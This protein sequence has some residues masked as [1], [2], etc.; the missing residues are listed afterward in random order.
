MATKLIIFVCT[1]NT[2]R[3]PMAEAFAKKWVQDHNLESRFTIVSRS[4]STDYEPP[5][6][7][8]SEHGI[9]VMREEFGLDTTS[10][11]STLICREDAEKAEVMIG[12]TRSHAQYLGMLFPD[13]RGKIRHLSQDVYDPWHQSYEVYQACARSMQPLVGQIMDEVT[14]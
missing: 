5:N 14:A 3:S 12:V 4:M 10:H 8:A 6:S 1:S 9:T 2:C 7:P 11:R 13:L